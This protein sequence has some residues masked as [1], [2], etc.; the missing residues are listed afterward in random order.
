[1]LP[2]NTY[3]DTAQF[4]YFTVSQVCIL[5]LDESLQKSHGQLA[6]HNWLMRPNWASWGEI[7]LLF[8]VG[9][10]MLFIVMFHA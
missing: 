4:G 3:H 10:G 7:C 9:A 5:H 8:T 2:V 6:L 1:M